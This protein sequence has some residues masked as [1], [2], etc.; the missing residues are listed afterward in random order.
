MST[1]VMR[2]DSPVAGWASGPLVFSFFLLGMARTPQQQTTANTMLSTMNTIIGDR[3]MPI[4]PRGSGGS[5]PRTSRKTGLVIAK[6]KSMT[7]LAGPEY[8]NGRTAATHEMIT[9]AMSTNM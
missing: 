7:R 2:V 5:T 8:G 6:M 4:P 9:L 1:G 3:S